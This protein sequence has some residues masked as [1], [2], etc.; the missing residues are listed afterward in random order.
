MRPA[1][2]EGEPSRHCWLTAVMEGAWFQ[3]P[4]CFVWLRDRSNLFVAWLLH[5]VLTFSVTQEPVADAWCW[6]ACLYTASHHLP[7]LPCLLGWES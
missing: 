4:E 2:T 3:S 7:V 5:T 1:V 6:C